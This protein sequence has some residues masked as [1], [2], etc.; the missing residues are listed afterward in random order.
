M[1]APLGIVRVHASWLTPL[2]EAHGAFIRHDTYGTYLDFLVGRVILR[3]V[4]ARG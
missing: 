4:T 3:R 1:S 2:G